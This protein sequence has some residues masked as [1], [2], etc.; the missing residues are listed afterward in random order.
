M[1]DP[2]SWLRH[3]QAVGTMLRLLCG[4]GQFFPPGFSPWRSFPWEAAKLWC[5]KAA[6][7][8][9]CIHYHALLIQRR[10]LRG[11]ITSMW[12]PQLPVECECLE[13]GVGL[14]LVAVSHPWCGLCGDLPWVPAVT[15]D[16]EV[17]M[18]K[19]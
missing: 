6:G 3:G 7:S 19:W 11:C 17:V 16:A 12:H 1:A 14:K 5:C 10:Q 9:C 15:S 4:L 18:L 2:L 8:W 13:N